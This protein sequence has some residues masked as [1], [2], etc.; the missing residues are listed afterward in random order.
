ML[1]QSAMKYDIEL[2][3]LLLTHQELSTKITGMDLMYALAR[4]HESYKPSHVRQILSKEALDKLDEDFKQNPR[5][6]AFMAKDSVLNK[7][8]PFMGS[9][10]TEAIAHSKKAIIQY[11]MNS[12]KILMKFSSADALKIIAEASTRNAASFLQSNPILFEKMSSAIQFIQFGL[13][14]N[15]LDVRGYPPVVWQFVL[16]YAIDT[17][18]MGLLKGLPMSTM[19]STNVVSSIMRVKDPAVK[20]FLLGNAAVLER[21]NDFLETTEATSKERKRIVK[22]LNPLNAKVLLEAFKKDLSALA[23]TLVGTPFAIEELKPLDLFLALT[24]LSGSPKIQSWIFKNDLLMQAVT[25]VISDSPQFLENAE[26]LNRLSPVLDSFIFGLAKNSKAVAVSILSNQNLVM[27][28]D[29]KTFIRVLKQIYE[30]EPQVK[31]VVKVMLM[32][33]VKENDTK[34]AG[35]LVQSDFLEYLGDKDLEEAV[36]KAG[37]HEGM[38]KILMDAKLELEWTKI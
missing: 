22:G 36:V 16:N 34:L 38:K 17:K 6:V 9:L 4:L 19:D 35:Y 5:M 32:D 11:M 24:H 13:E 1:L 28:M 20:E 8:S 30:N 21:L 37:K 26:V 10:L 14:S 2:Y 23:S 3:I 31:S 18:N 25:K 27:A 15:S 12:P 7:L 29:S 33:A